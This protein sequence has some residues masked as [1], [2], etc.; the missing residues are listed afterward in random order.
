MELGAP[1]EKD[2]IRILGVTPADLN[3]KKTDCKAENGKTITV[4]PV[5]L[6]GIPMEHWACIRK[7]R[8]S[9]K[10]EVL[11]NEL[12]VSPQTQISRDQ[13]ASWLDHLTDHLVKGREKKFP[14]KDL[15][16]W[17]H[18]S[19]TALT[20]RKQRQAE[21]GALEDGSDSSSGD[22]APAEASTLHGEGPGFLIMMIMMMAMMMMMMMMTV[23]DVMLARMINMMTIM[24]M[25]MVMM[26]I[27]MMFMIMMMIMMTLMIMVMM[28]TMMIMMM[29]LLLMVMMLTMLAMMMM[30]MIMMMV[31]MI[32]RP[33]GGVSTLDPVGLRRVIGPTGA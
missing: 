16:S 11:Q 4:Y 32:R 18:I 2:I 19:R 15:L 25:M 24:I 5:S 20:L 17:S 30:K 3:L 7:M 29:W 23:V 27:M 22:G 26:M 28:I 6:S 10:V 31:V 12:F 9:S 13:P 21:A 1:T 8:L 14:R 33:T